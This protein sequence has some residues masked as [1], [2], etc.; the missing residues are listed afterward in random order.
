MDAVRGGKSTGGH[1]RR[2]RATAFG[3]TVVY[4]ACD[5]EREAMQCVLILDANATQI[6]QSVG[7]PLA[8]IVTVSCAETLHAI[9]AVNW[10]RR[11]RAGR[12]M[13]PL[14]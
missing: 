3:Q 10:L 9:L 8:S 14:A 7:G 11:L 4:L 12:K 1:R 2:K 6:L 13:P 5:T